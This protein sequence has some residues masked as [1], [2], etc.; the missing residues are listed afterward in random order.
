MESA[1]RAVPKSPPSPHL[2]QGGV[3]AVKTVL[4]WVLRGR[5]GHIPFL[6]VGPT[7]QL[8]KKESPKSLLKQLV[9]RKELSASFKPGLFVHAW[10]VGSDQIGFETCLCQLLSY[11]TLG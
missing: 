6:V 4:S 7:A 9:R 2:G 1:W 8:V 5:F 11:V 10:V 3:A